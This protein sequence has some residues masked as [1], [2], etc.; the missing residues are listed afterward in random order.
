MYIDLHNADKDGVNRFGEVY[1]QYMKKVPRAN[2]LLD[3][4]KPASPSDG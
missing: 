1:E 2:F 4:M 3:F